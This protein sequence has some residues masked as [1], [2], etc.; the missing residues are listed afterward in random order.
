V[1]SFDLSGVDLEGPS[2]VVPGL[3]RPHGL[4][5]SDKSQAYLGLIIRLRALCGGTL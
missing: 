2:Y 3:V 5:R 4:R 1:A